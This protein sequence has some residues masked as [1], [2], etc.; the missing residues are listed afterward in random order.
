MTLSLQGSFLRFRLCFMLSQNLSDPVLVA[1]LVVIAGFCLWGIIKGWRTGKPP[2]QKG[3]KRTSL[4]ESRRLTII[5]MVLCSVL[6]LASVGA[7]FIFL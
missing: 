6:L 2:F 7:I 3:I 1:L 4:A 5:Q